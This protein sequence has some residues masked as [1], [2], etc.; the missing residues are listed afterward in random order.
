MFQEDGNIVNHIKPV[1]VPPS[2]ST[3]LTIHPDAMSFAFRKMIKEY[4][5]RGWRIDTKA[6]AAEDEVARA[7]P[8]PT[9]GADPKNWVLN[10][11]ILKPARSLS[12]AAE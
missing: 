1:H 10:P 8:S 3:E 5:A 9:R 6:M 11:V 4:E 12:A 7:I 2:L